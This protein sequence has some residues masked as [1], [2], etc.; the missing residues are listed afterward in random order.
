MSAPPDPPAAPPTVVVPAY[1]RPESTRRALRS[2]VDAG[3]TAILLVDDAGRGHGDVLGAEFP[4]V[5]VLRTETS[6]YWTG[7]IRLGIEHA[8][9]RGAR[10][11]LLFN[12]DVTVA[13]GYF[14]RLSATSARFPGAVIGSA[15]VYAQREGL[16]WAAGV[17]MEWFG[18]GFRVLHHGTGADDLP[19]EPFSVDWLFGMGTCVPAGVFGKIGLPDADRFPMAWG[20]ADF[21]LRASGAGIPVLLDPRLRLAHEVGPYD[22]RVAPAPRFSE[23][24]SWLGSRHHNISLS[25]QREVWR[26]HGPR[27][28]WPLSLAL[29]FA[30]LLVNFVRIRLLY[31]DGG[32]AEARGGAS[33]A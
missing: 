31:P 28:L 13:P 22:A 9:A 4:G 6:V 26:R 23:Y 14:E 29:R 20:D 21:T 5:E 12:Q 19:A 27:G 2:L 33:A 24:V 7:A 30:F 15:V 8:L 16:V 11:V 10:S 32:G 3:A 25:A 1:G 18:R 17:R